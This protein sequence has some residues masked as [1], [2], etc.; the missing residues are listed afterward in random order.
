MPDILFEDNHLLAI[1]KRAGDLSQPDAGGDDPLQT[2]ISA[3]IKKRD[4]KPGNVYLGTL[5]RL[6]R[7]VTGALLFAKT[8]KAAARMAEMIRNRTFHKY[9][10]AV[11]PTQDFLSD[12][13][14]K[15]EDNLYRDG[16]IT[17]VVAKNNPGDKGVLYIRR[18]VA[19]KNFSLTLIKL[20][21][22]RKHQIR[23]QLSFR[24]MPIVGDKKYGSTVPLGDGIALHAYFISFE[25]PVKKMVTEISAPLPRSIIT[26]LQSDG[27]TIPD[28][29]TLIEACH[30]F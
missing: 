7:P 21:T 20:E 9:Y 26:L 16:D 3:F 30:S 2:I 8:S 12:T 24:K 22:G 11:T 17:R 14:T 1:N 6:D 5:H 13:W 15:C 4:S 29:R 19:G 25:H 23:A 28:D 18:L 10:L 27:I